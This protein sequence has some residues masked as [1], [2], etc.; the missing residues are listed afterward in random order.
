MAKVGPVS[1][2]TGVIRVMCNKKLQLER[3]GLE[4]RELQEFLKI[5]TSNASFHIA[6]FKWEY[7]F[8]QA[9]QTYT[10]HSDSYAA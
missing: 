8:R 2:K 7:V 4:I 10:E 6:V 3:K 5:L 9:N 1:S